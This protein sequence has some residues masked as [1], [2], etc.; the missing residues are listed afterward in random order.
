MPTPQGDITS[1]QIWTQPAEEENN[2]LPT[3]QDSSGTES[4]EED[5]ASE[6]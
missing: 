5:Q 4:T 1:S 2:D 6:E 3:V